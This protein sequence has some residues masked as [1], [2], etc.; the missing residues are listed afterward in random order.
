MVMLF[1]LFIVKSCQL[2]LLSPIDFSTC[3]SEE[4]L[5]GGIS[6]CYFN[7]PCTF[8]LWHAIMFP[9]GITLLASYLFDMQ[10]G[11]HSL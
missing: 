10:V 3:L 1:V 7:F 11:F 4:L 8:N 9:D 2:E 5:K 6:A